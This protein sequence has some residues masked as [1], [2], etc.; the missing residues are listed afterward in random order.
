[1]AKVRPEFQHDLYRFIHRPIREA[2]QKDGNQFVERYMFGMQREFEAAFDK[3]RKLTELYDPEKTPQPRLLKDIVGLTKELD[4]ITR[5]IND[6]DLRKLISLA[7][8]LWKQK[9]LEIGYVNIVRLFTGKNA[10]VFNW[11]DYRMIVGEKS[12]GEEQ[13]GEDSWIISKVGVFGSTPAGNVVL[14]LP[15]E[16]VLRDR[17]IV[18]NNNVTLHGAGSFFA[19]GPTSGSAHYL[20]LHGGFLSL[21]HVSAYD[22][23]T[24][25]LTI[26]GWFRTGIAQD[27]VLYRKAAG[28]IEVELR[29][30]STANT[31]TYTLNDGT[32]TV[33][34]TLNAVANL[35][36]NNWRHVAL[37]VRRTG[38]PTAR[39]YLNGT[40]ATAGA[41]LGALGSL[42]NAG[43]TYIGASLPVVDNFQGDIDNLRVSRSAQY[44]ITGGT[45][46]VPPNSFI[47][48][49]EEQLDEFFTDVRVVDDGT[50]NHTLVKRILNLMRPVSE[51]LRIIYVR[52]FEDFRFG[53]GELVTVSPGAFVQDTTLR[54]P[55]GSVEVSDAN[56]SLDF[57]DYVLQARAQVESGM[58][59][60]VRFLAQDAS[61][62]YEFRINYST[63]ELSLY[64]V[65]SGVPTL[66][67]GPVV[68]DVVLGAFYVFTVIV[69]YND[70]GDVTMIKTF[71]DSNAIH[72]V[73]DSTFN[74]GTF[75][76]A[77]SVGTVSVVDDI[78]M[79]LMPV[80]VETIVPNQVI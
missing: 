1:M 43:I 6:Q 50:L 28:G 32:N 68:R 24:D 59:F 31:I 26:E 46:P 15:F 48:Y 37:I 64:K 27:A 52:V 78:E 70:I 34:E 45:I 56:G 39:L 66:L 71:L 5:D 36:D 21:P 72:S 4:N 63:R 18:N 60:S 44:V 80:T 55:G 42:T 7:V 16:N 74:K 2:D 25:S 51:R 57:R 12:F 11:F 65:V 79:F 61:N 47:E 41:A 13:L 76:F 29:Y 3:I 38:T 69:D 33:T 8:A 20:K 49:Q 40:E 22:F 35:D 54:M 58:Q 9:G 14:L 30:N 23:G 75:G 62:Y 77:S 53:K 10:R 73:M 17:S 67:A 19:Q